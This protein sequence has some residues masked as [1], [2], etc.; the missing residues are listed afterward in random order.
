MGVRVQ[1][2]KGPRL[3]HRAPRRS[4]YR[5]VFIDP[6]DC[7]MRPNRELNLRVHM[8]G[9]FSTTIRESRKFVRS[10]HVSILP[11]RLYT[12]SALDNLTILETKDKFVHYVPVF[13]VP[14]L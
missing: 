14:F 8:V 2:V 1:G 12:I 10:R 13:S 7:P 5:L 4:K 3:D 9:R 6:L 11:H